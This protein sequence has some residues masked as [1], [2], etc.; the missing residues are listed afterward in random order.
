[1]EKVAHANKAAASGELKQS[2][3]AAGADVRHRPKLAVGDFLSDWPQYFVS[4]HSLNSSRR[5]EFG[6]GG[7]C[8]S[9]TSDVSK[10][11]VDRPLS[12]MRQC[13]ND[14]LPPLELAESR[15]LSSPESGR[16]SPSAERGPAA[17]NGCLTADITPMPEVDH[18]VLVRAS[19]S[20]AWWRSCDRDPRRNEG[21]CWTPISSEAPRPRIQGD[22]P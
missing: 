12:K 15:H 4:R 18:L 13:A 8:R 17:T 16:C 5:T 6:A 14:P 3:W 21:V 20:R 2:R 1:M 10:I 9:S 19:P 11:A 22:G 7:R